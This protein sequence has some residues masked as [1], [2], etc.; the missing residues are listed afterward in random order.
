M[1]DAPTSDTITGAIAGV[2]FAFQ[3]DAPD[4]MAYA[5]VHLTSLASDRTATPAITARLTWRDGQPPHQRPVAASELIAMDRV[6]RDIYTSS[7][8]LYWFRVDDLRDLFLKFTRVEDRLEVVGD[9]YYRLGNRWMSDRIRRGVQWRQRG[10]L[11]ER[12]FP[13]LLSYMVYYPCWWWLE[14]R[15]DLH[16]IHAAGVLTDAGVILLAGASGAGKSTLAVALAHTP[17]ARLLSDSFVL[18]NGLDVA[19]VREPIL[20]DAW[21]T[22]WLGAL[23]ADLQRLG[24]LYGLGRR[25][26]QLPA[27]RCAEA[28]RAAL[29]IFPQRSPNRYLRRI[30]SEQAHQRLSAA[31]LV[32]NDL[33]RYWAYAAIL[34]HMVPGGLMARREA[35]LA[36]LVA[37]VPC[38]E[39]G[40]T[41]EA[42]SAAAS[43][44]IMQLLGDT[45]LRVVS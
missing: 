13:T 40:V 20:L 29:L 1:R 38:Y 33:R 22:G 12:R 16:P 45:Q 5:R 32:I 36:K 8:R 39:L 31:D 9:F 26:Y 17:G 2:N 25:G 19:A 4:L 23:G 21:S 7:E 15:R 6:D 10:M 37:G 43:D 18:H 35:H 24:R 44:A 14:Q 41:A 42:T 30:T 11:R 3:C 27:P 28:G 34:E